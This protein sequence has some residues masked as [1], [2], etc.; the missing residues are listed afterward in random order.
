MPRDYRLYLDDILQSIG[1]ILQY[2]GPMDFQEFSADRK[3]VDAVVRNLEVIGEASRNLPDEL[4]KTAPAI[5]W[6][7]IVALRNI[8]A[9]EY[10]QIT[11]SHLGHHS[12]QAS[13]SAGMLFKAHLSRQSGKL[14][15]PRITISLL[16][17]TDFL[18][19]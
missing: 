7:K 4:K 6:K 5:E 17:S 15:R 10:F 1:S 11:D 18:S 13:F 8:L 16:M 19:A 12:K 9:H 14:T 3:T 2:I